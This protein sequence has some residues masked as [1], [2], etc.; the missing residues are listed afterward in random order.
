MSL[1]DDLIIFLDDYG[2]KIAVILMIIFVILNL[3]LG[4]FRDDSLFIGVIV[5]VITVVICFLLVL[6]LPKF[7][8]FLGEFGIKGCV[9]CL[10]SIFK[11]I[12]LI[13]GVVC[14]FLNMSF[15]GLFILAGICSLLAI[16]LAEIFPLENTVGGTDLTGNWGP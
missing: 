1:I 9:G 5:I 11:A 4:T 13:V 7:W 6:L 8:S 2:R 14:S 10:S 3:L 15:G 12:I 16:I